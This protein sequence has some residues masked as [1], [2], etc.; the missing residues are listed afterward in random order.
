SSGKSGVLAT[1]TGVRGL[2]YTILELADRVKYADSA[3]RALDLQKTVSETPANSVRSCARCFES[4]L[5]DK[6]WFHDRGHWLEYLS[7]LATHRFNRFNLTFGLGYNDA[8]NIPDSYFY[9][10]YPFLLDVPGYNVRAAGLPDAERDRNLEMLR[11]ISD[12]TTAR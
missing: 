4:E 11:F 6:S 8:R 5:E 3:A 1:A 10:A 7:M 2:V 12:E 9:F